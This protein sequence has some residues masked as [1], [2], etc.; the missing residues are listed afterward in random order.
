VA[1]QV[2]EPER[3]GE[4]DAGRRR[5]RVERAEPPEKER[6]AEGLSVALGRE[7]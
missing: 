5:A 7:P 6:E 2:E 4:L 3:E 1:E